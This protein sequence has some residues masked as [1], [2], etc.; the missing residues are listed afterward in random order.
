ML[1]RVSIL[2]STDVFRVPSMCDMIQNF[3][4]NNIYI[5]LFG[6]QLSPRIIIMFTGEEQ[7]QNI[8]V[9]IIT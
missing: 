9:D 6:I 3:V 8:V 1:Q 2:D 4:E 7:Q 5:P